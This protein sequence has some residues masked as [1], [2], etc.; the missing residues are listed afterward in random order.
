MKI[1]HS[2][3]L[4]TRRMQRGEQ[5]AFDEFFADYFPRVYRF[6]VRRVGY[7]EDTV[8]EIVQATLCRA[9][10]KIAS[11]RGEAALFTWLCRLCSNEISDY[12]RRTRRIAQREVVL[13]DERLEAALGALDCGDRNDPVAAAERQQLGELIQLIVDYLP[14]RQG[15]ALEWKYVQGLSVR[16]IAQRLGISETAVQSLLARARQGFREG[17]EAAAR[18]QPDGLIP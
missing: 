15:N 16:E 3:K 4:L 12:F 14:A 17:F 6:T 7:D 8:R 11:Y 5:R 1:V 18:R 10:E 9:V 13:D 2:D